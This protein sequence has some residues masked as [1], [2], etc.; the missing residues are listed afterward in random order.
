MLDSRRTLLLRMCFLARLRR[1]IGLR[2]RWLLRRGLR[3]SRLRGLRRLR[4]RL[5]VVVRLLRLRWRLVRFWRLLG[6]RC[7]SSCIPPR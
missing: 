7:R 3:L 2:R 4:L 6:V 5:L 1:C